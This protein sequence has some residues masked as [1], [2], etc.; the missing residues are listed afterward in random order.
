MGSRPIAL[1]AVRAHVQKHAARAPR[2]RR[3]LAE[4]LTLHATLVGAYTAT[5]SGCTRNG[6][7]E[8]DGRVTSARSHEPSRCFLYG[9]VA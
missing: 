8:R 4:C 6:T 7:K 3:R 9:R 1:A 2:D 5:I